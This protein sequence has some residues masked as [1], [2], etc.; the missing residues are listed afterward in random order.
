MARQRT[1]TP[2]LVFYHLGI[3]SAVNYIGAETCIIK[4]EHMVSL[5]A[6]Q[7]L[8]GSTIAIFVRMASYFM[9]SG[10][11]HFQIADQQS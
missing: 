6:L 3:P 2:G 4:D 9:P 10:V 1:G 11:R 7:V 8:L 5:S